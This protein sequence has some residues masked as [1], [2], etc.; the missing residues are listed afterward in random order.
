MR[1]AL[2]WYERRRLG[3]GSIRGAGDRM[4]L[5]LH[6]IFLNRRYLIIITSLAGLLNHI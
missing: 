2:R 6:L 1:F 5:S 3:G 4:G